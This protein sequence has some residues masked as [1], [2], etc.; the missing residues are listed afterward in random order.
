MFFL[1]AACNKWVWLI[2]CSACNLFSFQN[3]ERAINKNKPTNKC[4]MLYSSCSW[5]TSKILVFHQKH[6]QECRGN[7]EVLNNPA[8]KVLVFHTYAMQVDIVTWFVFGSS[9]LPPCGIL[10]SGAHWAG[11]F[12]SPVVSSTSAA[13]GNYIIEHI[14]IEL[15]IRQELITV[16]F[17]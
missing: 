1:L 5:D 16:A 9:V 6:F 15:V 10:S 8:R 12:V 11:S 7:V 17:H 4:L 13:A 2:L 14:H 3:K